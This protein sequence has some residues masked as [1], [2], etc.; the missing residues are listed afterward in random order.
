MFSSLIKNWYTDS[1][2]IYRVESIKENHITK[3]ERVLIAENIPCRIYRSKTS[4]AN[5]ESTAAT[6]TRGDL[7][8]VDNLV[9]IKAGDELHVIRGGA[10]GKDGEHARMFAGEPHDYFTPFGGVSPDIQYKEVP[11]SST[12]RI[13]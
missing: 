11:L 13:K 9:D 5:M 1:V 3:Q 6:I 4:Y 2:T 7:M 12:S 8:A 10:I